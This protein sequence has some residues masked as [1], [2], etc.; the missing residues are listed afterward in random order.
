MYVGFNLYDVT[1]REN[2]FTEAGTVWYVFVVKCAGANGT[3]YL[4][5]TFEWWVLSRKSVMLERCELENALPVI[6]LYLLH[7]LYVFIDLLYIKRHHSDA[8]LKSHRNDKKIMKE[9][10]RHPCSR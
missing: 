3:V 9:Q 5:T 6:P 7:S 1:Q 8:N 4:Q 2:S 10:L